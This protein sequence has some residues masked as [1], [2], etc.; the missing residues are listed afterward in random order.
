VTMPDLVNNTVLTVLARLAMLGATAALPVAGWLL[1]R[2][3][4]TMD[5]VSDKADTIHEQLLGAASDVKLLQQTQQIQQQILAD[6][7]ARVRT[8]E[9]FPIRH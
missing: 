8:L 2:G 1:V 5:R 4:N 7:E 6:H 3:V 9:G